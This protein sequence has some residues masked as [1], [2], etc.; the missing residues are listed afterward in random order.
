MNATGIR[1]HTS[2]ICRKEQCLKVTARIFYRQKMEEHSHFGNIH[3]L[4]S[5]V[6]TTVQLMQI[7]M[8][9]L[10]WKNC[11]LTH[12]LKLTVPKATVCCRIKCKR[13]TQYG[14]ESQIWQIQQNLMTKWQNTFGLEMGNSSL[15]ESSSKTCTV[16]EM[17]VARTCNT[18]ISFTPLLQLLCNLLRSALLLPTAI[19]SLF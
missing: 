18:E 11:H 7:P 15:L 2:S 12:T 8:S 19:L 10:Q 9:E 1:Q 16:L 17:T 5:H 13:S 14:H 4:F 6:I 3:K